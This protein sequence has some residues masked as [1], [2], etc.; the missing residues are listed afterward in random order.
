M[1]MKK[2][3]YFVIVAILAAFSLCTSCTKDEIT[4]WT[5]TCTADL[6][7]TFQIT[8]DATITITNTTFVADI[9]TNQIGGVAEEHQFQITG[10]VDDNRLT[11]L[12][13]EFELM[14]NNEI[15][16]VTLTTGA[17]DINGAQLTGTGTMTVIPAGMTT[18]IN[19]IYNLTGTKK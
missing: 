13:S 12:N 19:G 3:F 17:I 1:A 4:E 14:M 18:P 10:T 9:T 2:T 5:L 7:G 8:A 11:V 16:Y 15:E 6:G